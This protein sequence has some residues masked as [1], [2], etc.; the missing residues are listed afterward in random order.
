MRLEAVEE[1]EGMQVGAPANSPP[2]RVLNDRGRNPSPGYRYRWEIL[3][4]VDSGELDAGSVWAP[5][6]RWYLHDHPE[7]KVELIPSSAV[8]QFRCYTAVALRP[9]EEALREALDRISAEIE[10]SGVVKELAAKYAIPCFT[11]FD[12]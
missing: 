9:E 12:L 10:E 8:I 6:A 7:L 4:A 2:W 11:P 5:T 1:L 3:K